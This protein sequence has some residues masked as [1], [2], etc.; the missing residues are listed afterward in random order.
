MTSLELSRE[1]TVIRLSPD[2]HTLRISTVPEN[3]ITSSRLELWTDGIL[4]VDAPL[5]ASS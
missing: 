4:S 5:I 1:V 3:Y 2:F